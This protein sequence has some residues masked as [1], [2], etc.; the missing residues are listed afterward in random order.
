MDPE[1][2]EKLLVNGPGGSTAVAVLVVRLLPTL[3]SVIAAA[4]P[5]AAL[6][7]VLPAKLTLNPHLP[8]QIIAAHNFRTEIIR[9]R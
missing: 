8:A 2:C 5:V 4:G 3:G 9:E 1:N 7:H 6:H